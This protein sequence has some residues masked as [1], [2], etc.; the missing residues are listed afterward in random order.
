MQGNIYCVHCFIPYVTT[1]WPQLFGLMGDGGL[2]DN[3]A[4]IIQN[5]FLFIAHIA[6]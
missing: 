1:V 6:S 5:Y 3:K 4:R 2:N